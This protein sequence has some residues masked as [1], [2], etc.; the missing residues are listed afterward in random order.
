MFTLMYFTPQNE[1]LNSG[2]SAEADSPLRH[3]MYISNDGQHSIGAARS[4]YNSCV[5][6]V[7][8]S[9]DARQD[10]LIQ[11]FLRQMSSSTE[12]F[13]QE[14]AGFGLGNQDFAYIENR[15]RQAL[16][17]TMLF[18]AETGYDGAGEQGLRTGHEQSFSENINL[19]HTVNLDMDE[20]NLGSSASLN[21]PELGS[22]NLSA[23]YLS[24]NFGEQD[25]GVNEGHTPLESMYNS[26]NLT[27][28]KSTDNTE[29][30]QRDIKKKTPRERKSQYEVS[31]ILCL[32]M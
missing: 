14:L 23:S 19:V 29:K 3:Q 6:P 17:P 15:L 26:G 7:S 32:I 2:Y 28:Y 11:G 22:S 21:L 30:P 18:S 25:T 24:R 9:A 5:M 8:E 20:R 31:S 10:S 4:D 27:N 16:S 1:P 13:N 12:G